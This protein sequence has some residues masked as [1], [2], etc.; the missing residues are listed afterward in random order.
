MFNI[1]RRNKIPSGLLPDYPDK[2]DYQLLAIQPEKVAL[3]EEYDL[4]TQMS[5]IGHQNW[6]SCW[7][8]AATAVKEYLDSKQYGKTLNL[9]EKFVYHTGKT[10]S[11]LWNIQG[12]YLRTGL[13]ALCKYGAPLLG[14]YPDTKEKNWGTY[15]KKEPLPEI[16]KKA[17]K[18]RG[19]TY[20]SVGKTLE[21]F[22]QAIYQQKAPVVF[23][24]MWHKSYNKPAKDG[25]LPLP[26][27]SVGGHAVVAVGWTKN[28]LWV[29]NSWGL[30]HG[31]QG[32]FYI[33]F[34]EFN[35]HTIWNPWCLLD[36]STQIT[37]WVAQKYIQKAV[38]YKPNDLVE[39]TVN[40]LNVREK[41]TVNSASLTKLKSKDRC[42]IIE[43]KNN[44]IQ[45][46]EYSW[47]K[48]KTQRS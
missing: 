26:D 18:Y 19:K 21:D 14:D 35:L 46:E 48:I 36:L 17:E 39:S 11:Q 41:P 15:A 34:E 23:G 47:W 3:P 22:K 16:Y 5:P 25:R 32:Y 27:K 6:G 20:W 9:S 45:A 1:F 8:W 40:D 2:N 44:G 7:A 38:T 42:V 43:D 33:P 4:R 30:N 37:G 29:R 12:D 31:S 24:M 10:I 13:K 28:K